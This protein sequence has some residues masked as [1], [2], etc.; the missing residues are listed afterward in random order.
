MVAGVSIPLIVSDQIGLSRCHDPVT[1]GV[2]FPK[3]ALI[4]PEQ[5][6]LSNTYGQRQIL[7]TQVLSMWS[8][9]SAKW[10]LLDFLASTERGEASRYELQAVSQPE[11]LGGGRHPSMLA[12][13]N[14]QLMIS[15]G[16]AEFIVDPHVFLPFC[17]V[18]V[19]GVE[20][21]DPCASG[22]L[23]TDQAGEVFQPC[24]DHI[25][26]D[27]DGPIRTTLRCSGTFR[28]SE[29]PSGCEFVARIS[30]Y[31]GH[32]LAKIEFTVRNPRAA[33]HA[34]GLWDLGDRGSIFFTDLSFKFGVISAGAVQTKWSAESLG[35]LRSL[36]DQHVVIYQDSSGGQAWNSLNHLDR[37]GNLTVAFRGYRVNAG[38]D[39]LAEGERASPTLSIG[40]SGSIT[41][42]IESFWQ[43]FPKC[44]EGHSGRLR[45]G[46]FPCESR[47]GFELQGGEQKTHTVYVEFGD[48]AQEV[49][50]LCRAA[51]PLVARCTPEWYAKT[52]AF[53]YLLA[54]SEDPC[55]HPLR[56]KLEAVVN[57]AVDGA[58]SFFNRREIIDEYGWRNFGDV[59]ADHEAVR[60][61]DGTP[62]IAHYNNQYDL[63]FGA[64][65]QYARTGNLSWYRLFS[66]LARHVID[67]DLYH[68][69]ADRSAFNGGLFW[70]TDHYTDAGLATHRTYTHE[71]PQAQEGTAYG[72]GP[73]CEH[74]Y[75]S[76]LLHYYW[77]TGD[78]S[79]FEA[80]VSL[81]EWVINMDAAVDDPLLWIDRRPTGLASATA[82]RDY[83]G[84]GRGSGN[85]ISVL[86]DA[87]A[88]TGHR[89]YVDKA[90]ELIRRVIHPADDIA[91]RDLS[92]IE[93]RWSY[94]VF[95]QVLGRYLEF[96]IECEEIDFMYG[97]ARA[98]LLHYASWMA[99]HEVPYSTVLDRVQIP[100]ETWPAQDIRKSVVFD[101]AVK[102]AEGSLRRRF[103]Q[104]AEDFFGACLKD[105][106]AYPTH[107]L[108]RPMVLLITNAFVHSYCRVHAD[109][110][111]PK[112]MQNIDFSPPARFYPRHRELKMARET[113]H[114][115]IGNVRRVKQLLTAICSLK[116]CRSSNG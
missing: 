28:S 44:L 76:G 77:M 87:F 109:E 29:R 84:P 83:H 27:T 40:G 116:T 58:S 61:S 86:L 64:I 30:F 100:T 96:K 37:H 73:A 97:Y 99:D 53:P 39:L 19:N 60:H 26:I 25:T 70:H 38:D 107:T 3:G 48:Q 52:G 102:H 91:A 112:P 42:T 33:E 54:I 13:S 62:L 31:A 23:L 10:V 75:A 43:N 82:H 104:K 57:G 80:V 32:R 79:A 69:R 95:L 81:A 4:T 20:V 85:S 2:P 11:A 9:G 110:A 12:R 63:I 17:R 24:I 49:S 93:Y 92:D 21:L 111:S 88:A 98:A 35:S 74:N 72:G 46:L 66:D 5:L 71:S 22:V 90:E 45:I 89:A 47:S 115:V 7:Q 55:S 114:R 18:K 56:G 108:T 16:A 106:F 103:Q 1:I 14:D 78:P 105:L 68:T 50:P 6:I 8:D 36:P 113:V 59:Y 15:T 34:G 65:G 51:A 41:A 101:I 94:T 67:I